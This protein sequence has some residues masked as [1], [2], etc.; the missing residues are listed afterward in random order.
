MFIYSLI[1][2]RGI[3]DAAQRL[4]AIWKWR[5]IKNFKFETSPLKLTQRP[6]IDAFLMMIPVK[7]EENCEK[8]EYD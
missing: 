5:S 3:W 1:P 2:L 7:L 6:N 4:A 8:Y